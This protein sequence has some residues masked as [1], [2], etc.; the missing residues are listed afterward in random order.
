MNPAHFWSHF[1]AR[2]SREDTLMH[3]IIS[4]APANLWEV[5]LQLCPSEPLGGL[6]SPGA[7]DVRF[8]EAASRAGAVTRPGHRRV[9][10]GTQRHRGRDRRQ[11]RDPAPGGRPPRNDRGLLSGF[12]RRDRSSTRRH[13]DSRQFRKSRRKQT[14]PRR[15]RR[16][17]IEF[18]VKAAPAEG[19]GRAA[20]SA[21]RVPSS[22]GGSHRF[23]SCAAHY[24]S[25]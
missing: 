16:D 25:P 19:A 20:N 2:R 6:T 23:E 18:A 11:P 10:I 17:K 5:L 9:R 13:P 22:H 12:R 1:R 21:A 8:R 15:R 4:F 24:L 14:T 3:A 7:G